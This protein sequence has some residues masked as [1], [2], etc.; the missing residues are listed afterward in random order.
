M[1]MQIEQTEP[2]QQFLNSELALLDRFELAA[3]LSLTLTRTKNHSSGAEKVG[4]CHR[5]N[6]RLCV[7]VKNDH[8]W[9]ESH[10]SCSNRL[11]P[12]C[13]RERAAK[14]AAKVEKFV[15]ET[16]KSDRLRFIVFAE[17]SVDSFEEG[18]KT[19]WDSWT[20]MRR[21]VFWQRHVRGAVVSF[22]TTYNHETKQYHPHLNV[23]VEG[24]YIPFEDLNA[25][26]VEASEGRGHTSHIQKAD[27][28]TVRELIKYV[29]KAADLC[30]PDEPEILDRFFDVVKGKRLVR[31]YGTFFRMKVDEEGGRSC[32]DCGEDQVYCY[33]ELS[34]VP[35]M[36][37]W[38]IECDAT[39]I[40]RPKF[41]LVPTRFSL[42]MA[43]IGSRGG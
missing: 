31:T 22:E 29:A 2:N 15:I 32:P 25:A 5:G 42:A 12:F 17:R 21:S 1:E 8:K 33:D 36:S 18:Y 24:S 4:R 13:A 10:N 35:A 23:L 19:L 40:L 37:W 38:Q 11:C 3:R 6:F 43:S 20:S 41:G 14:M 39:G 27:A 34:G 16:G 26:W 30:D 7:C 9:V 28:G